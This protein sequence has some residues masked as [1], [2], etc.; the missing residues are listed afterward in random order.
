MAEPRYCELPAAH[1]G[2][3]VPLVRPQPCL[4]RREGVVCHGTLLPAAHRQWECTEGHTMW[5]NA[6]VLRSEP[7]PPDLPYVPWFARLRDRIF[8]RKNTTA[9]GGHI[10]AAGDRR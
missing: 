6:G 5:G 3:C 10:E 4:T 2:P 1:S 9:S 7:W 8:G